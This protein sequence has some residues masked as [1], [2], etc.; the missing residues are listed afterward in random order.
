MP[1]VVLLELFEREGSILGRIQL[2]RLRLRERH[3]GQQSRRW[4]RFLWLLGWKVP[5]EKV[6]EAE[7][8]NYE[9]DS[10]GDWML[11]KLD[12]WSHRLL[13]V[14]KRTLC[15]HKV[16]QACEHEVTGW[17]SLAILFSD[18]SVTAPR[19]LDCV[20]AVIFTNETILNE[21]RATGNSTVSDPWPCSTTR[22]STLPFQ[23]RPARPLPNPPA[24]M[25]P[26]SHITR[27]C[28]LYESR[29]STRSQGSTLA[30][31]KAVTEARAS[32]PS[33]SS[34]IHP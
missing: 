3:F 19:R 15:T 21:M 33:S 7:S 34:L 20:R 8:E 6:K 31:A 17:S 18:G 32:R 12:E 10:D 16:E 30:S 13:S 28:S 24:T 4:R 14:V 9:M 25:I 5:D 23:Q 26:Q 1:A 2:D 11:L 22:H 27:T 29:S